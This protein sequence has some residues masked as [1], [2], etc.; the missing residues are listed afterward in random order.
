MVTI[1]DN[2]SSQDYTH[3]D[4]QTTLLQATPGFKPFTVQDILCRMCMQ[5]LQCKRAEKLNIWQGQI[6]APK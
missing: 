1:T 6:K 3:L 4:D 2:S 5:M